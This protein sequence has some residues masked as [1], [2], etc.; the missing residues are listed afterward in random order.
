MGTNLGSLAKVYGYNALNIANLGVAFGAYST[1]LA[2]G[3]NAT[4]YNSVGIGKWTHATDD[5]TTLFGCV[6]TPMDVNITGDLTVGGSIASGTATITASS[7]NT[8]V[9]G[10]TTLFINPGA[11]VV[12]GGFAGGVNGQVLHVIIVDG[13]QAVTLENEEA[14]GTQKLAMHESSDETLTNARGGFTFVFNSITGFW[15]DVSHARHV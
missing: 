15:H 3:G 9:S 6:G 8:D 11:A 1:N 14:S 10:I 2:Y 13:D 4:G 7:D 5:N 12:I